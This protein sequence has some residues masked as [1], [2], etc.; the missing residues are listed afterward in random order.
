MEPFF[1]TCETCRAKLKVR[2]PALVGE[3]HGCPKCGG[4]VMIALPAPLDSP[5]TL[6]TATLIAAERQ[7]ASNWTDAS[8]SFEGLDDTIASLTTPAAPIVDSE[9]VEPV[10]EAAGVDAPP[11]SAGVSQYVWTTAIAASLLAVAGLGVLWAMQLGDSPTTTQVASLP[12]ADDGE[13]TPPNDS[14]ADSENSTV[15]RVEA[16]K[17]VVES[18]LESTV[19]DEPIS[20][21]DESR[22][23]PELP[24]L[25]VEPPVVADSDS[26]EPVANNVP[27]NEPRVLDPLALDPVDLDL[28]LTPRVAQATPVIA[29][30]QPAEIEDVESQPVPESERDEI[31]FAPGTFVRGPT[32]LEQHNDQPLAARLAFPLA[33]LKLQNVALGVACNQLAKLAELGVTLR[34]QTLEMA[35][36]RPTH[37]ISLEVQNTT[38]GGML[39]RIAGGLKLELVN[40][41]Q[42]VALA[43]AGADKSR[44]VDYDVADLLA[45][46]ESA[47]GLAKLLQQMVGEEWPSGSCVVNQK[48]ITVRQSLAV[49]YQVLRCLERLRLARGGLPRSRYPAELLTIEPRFAAAN[50]ALQHNTTVTFVDYIALPEALDF[51]S[52]SSGRLILVDWQRLADAE[53]TVETLVAGSAA[54]VPL[55]D[56]LDSLCEPLGLTWMPLDGTTLWL[57]TQ[58][59]ASDYA[60]VEFYP[61]K[62]LTDTVALSDRLAEKLPNEVMSRAA[63]ADDSASGCVVVRGDASVHRLISQYLA[64]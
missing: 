4:M 53:L 2:D 64:D 3:I 41:G 29:E 21:D 12:S 56:A 38:V 14:R 27:K 16:A 26:A 25:P 37:P 33:E 13:P 20:Q 31:R 43:K 23:L 59:A 8:D 30:A 58:D 39:Q 11:P 9:S 63:F 17:P 46:D 40:T 42:G 36:F 18:D 10:T 55:S 28:L 32:S 47:D 62:K 35:A 51:L 19:D 61:A 5:T 54:D 60:W 7:P 44:T 52:Q 57:T 49:Q 6:E 48:T 1:V 34:P 24:T 45:A 22:A 50:S 15:E